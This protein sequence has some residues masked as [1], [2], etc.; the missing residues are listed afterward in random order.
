M[1]IDLSTEEFRVQSSG[2]GSSWIFL[3]EPQ[4]GA[5]LILK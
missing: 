2:R 5:V 4:M 1:R 3:E